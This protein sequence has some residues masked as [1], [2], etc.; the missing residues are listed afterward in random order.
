MKTNGLDKK[1]SVKMAMS[2]LL[3]AIKDEDVDA[4]AEAFCAAKELDSEY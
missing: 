2:D 3:Q 4:M 1:E